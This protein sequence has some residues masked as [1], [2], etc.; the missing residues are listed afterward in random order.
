MLRS[1]KLSSTRTCKVLAP[2]FKLTSGTSDEA[3]VEQ[4]ASELSKA[5]G[6]TIVFSMVATSCSEH[7]DPTEVE[8]FVS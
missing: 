8:V 2:L 1:V 3:D 4:A 5:T 7:A 6:A